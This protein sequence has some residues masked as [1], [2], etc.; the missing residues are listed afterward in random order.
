MENGDG[1]ALWEAIL[2]APAGRRSQR[3][4]IETVAPPPAFGLAPL[5]GVGVAREANEKTLT[6]R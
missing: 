6:R 5:F 2:R 4:R 1:F 3:E